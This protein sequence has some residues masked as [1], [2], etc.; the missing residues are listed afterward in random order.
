VIQTASIRLSAGKYTVRTMDRRERCVVQ[1]AS[2]INARLMA[3]VSTQLAKGNRV[4]RPDCRR[5]K[6]M[7]VMRTMLYVIDSRE[8]LNDV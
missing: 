5:V 7:I 4:S 3:S 1:T 6:V 2:R 8:S